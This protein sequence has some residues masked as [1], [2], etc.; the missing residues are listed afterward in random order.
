[1]D[2]NKL[3]Y[4]VA[5]RGKTLSA[6]GRALEISKTALYRKMSGK[7]E[8]TREEIERIIHFLDLSERDTMDIFFT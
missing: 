7:T 4:F 3:R 2:T 8:F 6:L 5:D 1:M